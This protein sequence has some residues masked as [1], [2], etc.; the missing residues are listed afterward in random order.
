MFGPRAQRTDVP[1]PACEHG[2]L[3]IHRSCL[4]TSFRCAG[5]GERFG[6]EHLARLL[7]DARFAELAELVGDRLSDRV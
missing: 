3:V 4:Q 7:D 5:C 6:L 1:C 2:A